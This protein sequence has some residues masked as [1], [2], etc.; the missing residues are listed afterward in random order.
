MMRAISGRPSIPA[1]LAGAL[2]LDGNPLRRASDRADAWIRVGLLAVFL[3][4]GPMAAV[5]AG[6]WV[7]QTGTPGRGA[8]AHAVKAVLLQ[9]AAAVHAGAGPGSGAQMWVRAR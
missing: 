2:A 7:H 5:A 6:G 9:P 8:G 3:I 4:A 1:R